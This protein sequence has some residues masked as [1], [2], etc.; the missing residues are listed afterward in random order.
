VHSKVVA[1]NTKTLWFCKFLAFVLQLFRGHPFSVSL[2]GFGLLFYNARWYSPTLGRF[3]SADTVIPP[4]VQGLDRYA[5][6]NNNP[7]RYTDPSGHC[8]VGG[9]EMPDDTPACRWNDRYKEEKG[10]DLKDWVDPVEHPVITGGYDFG[11]DNGTLSG[12]LGVD[13]N[14][15]DGTKIVASGKGVVHTSDTCDLD[16]CNNLVGNHRNTTNGGYGNVVIVEYPYDS[17]PESIRDLIRVGQSLF[18]LYAHLS[19]ISDLVEGDK[20]G[21]GTV[22]GVVGSTGSSTGAHL[23]LEVRLG[24]P[25]DLGFGEL[26]GKGGFYVDDLWQDWWRLAVI[27]PHDIFGIQVLR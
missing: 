1:G 16:P 5:Y 27:N 19:S 11:D 7:L 10:T 18:V 25:G 21:P 22:I 26:A 15:P 23:H 2:D 4:G 17:L 3:V 24:S 6:V 13:L 9:H 8:V 20:V 12:H 14:P